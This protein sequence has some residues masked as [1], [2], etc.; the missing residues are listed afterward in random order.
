[1]ERSPGGA[2]L[3]LVHVDQSDSIE[4]PGLARLVFEL[5]I[6]RKSRLQGLESRGAVSPGPEEKTD[7]VV[8]RGLPVP[9]AEL[10]LDRESPAIGAQGFG[11]IARLAEDARAVSQQLGEGFLVGQ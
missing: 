9:V 4:R 7:V 5:A 3:V 6:E 2:L 10:F 8:S 11:G 1:M